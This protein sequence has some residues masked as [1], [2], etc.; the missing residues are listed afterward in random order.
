[1]TIAVD[2][3]GVLCEK[4]WPEIGYPNKKLIDHLVSLQKTGSKVILN[5]M[6]E[7]YKYVDKNGVE[8]DLLQEALDFCKTFGLLFDAVNDNL[9]EN[10]EQFGHNSRKIS[11]NIYIDDQNAD[12]DF[13]DTFLIPFSYH[14]MCM[15]E[16]KEFAHRFVEKLKNG[17]L[18]KPIEPKDAKGY[19][20]DRIH[21]NC[22]TL[23]QEEINAM[24]KALEPETEHNK[25]IP[26]V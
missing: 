13:N 18:K 20:F 4:K 2:F 22:H 14:R 26:P 24:L 7:H 23:S 25:G 11:A 5:T 16:A 9:P 3:D 6:R 10:V 15:D 8:R 12:T 21:P 17:E 19:E 1:M